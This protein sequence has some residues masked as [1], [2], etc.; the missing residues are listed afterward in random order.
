[1]SSNRE[2]QQR[3]GGDQ[4]RG[5]EPRQATRTP[6]DVSWVRA[7]IEKDDYPRLDQ[8]AEEIGRSLRDDSTKTQIR[9]IFGT[10]KRLEALKARPAALQRELAMLRP[11]L[12]YTAAR[13]KGLDAL[14]DVLIE[15]SKVVEKNAA[16]S[17]QRLVDLMEAIL[18]YSYAREAQSDQTREAHR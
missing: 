6:T 9:V 8:K 14:R 12:A 7:V 13:A 1:M 18:C 2:Q 17:T 4:Q 15:A 10:V 5:G 11:R 16:K 3:R